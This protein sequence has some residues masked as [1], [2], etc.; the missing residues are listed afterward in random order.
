M[1][2]TQLECVFPHLQRLDQSNNLVRELSTQHT[3][4]VDD[5]DMMPWV[6]LAMAM[7]TQPDD[8]NQQI[9]SQTRSL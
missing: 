4:I 3:Y 8:I 7:S 2:H 9:E 6:A 1:G 5:L